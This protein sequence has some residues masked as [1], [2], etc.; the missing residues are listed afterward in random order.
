[1]TREALGQAPDLGV[2]GGGQPL[3]QPAPALPTLLR[4]E[5]PFKTRIPGG[6]HKA[7]FPLATDAVGSA[8]KSASIDVFYFAIRSMILPSMPC[9]ATFRL[10]LVAGA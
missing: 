1:M 8:V 5:G 10:Q 2:R 9:T 4:C 3:Q 6:Y 7:V